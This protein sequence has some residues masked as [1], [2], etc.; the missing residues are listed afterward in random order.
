M[1]REASWAGIQ[2]DR[3]DTLPDS[4]SWEKALAGSCLPSATR[5]CKPSHFRRAARLHISARPAMLP[6]VC[7]QSLQSIA[8][9]RDPSRGMRQTQSLQPLAH[10]LAARLHISA[11]PAMLQVARPFGRWAGLPLQAMLQHAVGRCISHGV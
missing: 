5:A 10:C 2:L 3:R 1:R 11:K 6:A 9:Q 7:H 8:Y 4:E